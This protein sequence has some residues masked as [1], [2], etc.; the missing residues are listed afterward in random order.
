MKDEIYY[1]EHA[2]EFANNIVVGDIVVWQTIHGGRGTQVGRI[3]V[4]AAISPDRMTATIIDGALE[5]PAESIDYRYEVVDARMAWLG[6][7]NIARYR[8]LGL[9]P[10]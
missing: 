2:G 10:A 4:V 8:A 5:L 3:G 1:A 6:R 7:L 9:F